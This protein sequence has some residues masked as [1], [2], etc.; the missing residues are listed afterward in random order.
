[1]ST[2]LDAICAATLTARPA[3]ATMLVAAHPDDETIGAGGRLANLQLWVVHVTDG[4]PRDLRDANDA[5][6]QTRQAYAE[7]RRREL[8]SALEQVG[9]GTERTR[10]LSVVD[11][12]ASL[13][14][15][16]LTC[17]LA[18]LF[19]EI[20]P[21]V[22][23]TH[24]Y[25]GGHP[26][27]DATAFSVHAACALV[28]RKGKPPPEIIEFAS[29]HDR[30]GAMSFFEFL[31]AEGCI[32]RTILLSEQERA[33]KRQMLDCFAT[34]QKTIAP[35]PIDRECYRTSPRYDF[36]APPHSGTLF[37]ERYPWGMTG[38]RWRLL[39]ASAQ[40]RLGIGGR[41]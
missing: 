33:L 24:P 17:R 2:L 1:M 23:L 5:G 21:A 16:E 14:L 40:E 31:P 25:E 20:D 27:H 12:E 10:A 41:L 36:T 15:V 7:A 28:D 38:E 6:F 19:R 11:Q 9:I 18:D 34:Q 29:Y 26:D 22:I 39:A 4:S 8:L 32:E 30:A 35:F 37:Y 3:F 13:D